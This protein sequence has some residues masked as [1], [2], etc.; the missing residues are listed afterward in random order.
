MKRSAVCALWGTCV[1]KDPVGFAA[2]TSSSD[3]PCA[4]SI[5][6]LSRTASTMSRCAIRRRPVGGRTV[7]WN[8]LGHRARA[9]NGVAEP[10]EQSCER[11]AVGQIDKGIARAGL[12]SSVRFCDNWRLLAAPGRSD[13]GPKPP[14]P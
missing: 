8:D 12:Q 9:P 7:P 10:G 13:T 1:S 11:A 3:L 14:G 4:T 2:M 6:T 5:A